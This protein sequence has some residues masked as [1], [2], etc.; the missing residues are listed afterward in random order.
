M[1]SHGGDRKSTIKVQASDI[2]PA[3][4]DDLNLDRR[5]VSEWRE[6]RM[7]LLP[8]ALPLRLETFQ[9]AC[10]SFRKFLILLA[11]P[12]GLEPATPRLEVLK[13]AVTPG[14]TAQP[15]APTTP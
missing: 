8:L 5:R 11:R 9:S 1:A 13:Q 4:Y 3:T 6:L 7:R 12:A 15:A 10:E 14:N 2:D